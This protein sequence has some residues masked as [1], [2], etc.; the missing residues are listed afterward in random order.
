MTCTAD[1]HGTYSAVRHC[2]CTCPEARP[3]YL[4][5]RKRYSVAHRRGVSLRVPATGTIR[6]VQA[7]QYIGYSLVDLKKMLGYD[8]KSRRHFLATTTRTDYTV[9]ATTANKVDTLYR[10]LCMTPA[11]GPHAAR[12]SSMARKRGYASPLAWNDID[13][14]GEVPRTEEQELEEKRAEQRKRERE[15]KRNPEVRA[16]INAQ[17]HQRRKARREQQRQEQESAA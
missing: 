3:D 17:N 15:R 13:D 11:T 5:K 1:R 8:H 9:W 16:R 7:L 6:R 14:P 4:R 12:L 10:R 2:N